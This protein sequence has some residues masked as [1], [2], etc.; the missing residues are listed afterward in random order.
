MRKTNTC[1]KLLCL[2]SAILIFISVPLFTIAETAPWDCT[3]CGKKGN[4]GN[5]C[6]GCGHPAPGI[7]AAQAEE[8]PEKVIAKANVTLY[9]YD[10]T[11]TVDGK[12]YRIIRAFET[13]L[14]NLCADAFRDQG[15]ADIGIINSGSIR[16]Q[17]NAGELKIQDIQ[18]LLPFGNHIMVVEASGQQILDALEWSV[19]SE[20]SEF[21]G[22]LQVSG[23]SFE[24][25][26]DIESP[27]IIDDKDMPAGI[28]QTK[29]RRVYNV[30]V[31]GETLDPSK[32]YSVASTDYLLN[33][34]DGYTVFQLCKVLKEPGK[35]DSQTLIDY[36]VGTLGGVIEKGYDQ[37]Y[38]QQRIV[39]N[40]TVK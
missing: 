22:F 25:N 8:D 17:I 1:T 37:P 23:I 2:L 5:F 38:G 3:E 7:K 6:G 26:G 35:I 12:A 31:G 4:T 34:G 39:Y 36:I 20:P 40:Y 11:F 24:I 29:P 32:S 21:S 16:T 28:D 14:G 10:P 15:G 9:Y 19:H 33:G 30:R 13:N 27:V 18:K